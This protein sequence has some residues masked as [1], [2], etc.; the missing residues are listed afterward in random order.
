MYGIERA[1]ASERIIRLSEYI[2]IMNDI[3]IILSDH[4]KKI[5]D[6]MSKYGL[7]EVGDPVEERK[8]EGGKGEDKK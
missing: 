3:C 7:V 5:K 8:V 1:K 4:E 2:Y 6:S